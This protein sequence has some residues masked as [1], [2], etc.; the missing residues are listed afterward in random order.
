MGNRRFLGSTGRIFGVVMAVILATT[1]LAFAQASSTFNGRILDQGDAVLPGVTV[2]VTNQ[3]TGVVRTTV[4][5]EEGQYFLPGLEPG[6][7]R[8]ATELQGFQAP[9][10]ENVTLGVNTTLSIDFQM[11]VAGLN[12]A[13]TV[14]GDAPLIEVTQSKVAST[15]ETTELQNLPMI[16][17]NVSG[18]L[19]L[20]P[21]A[22][23]IAPTHRTKGNVGSV[24]FGGSAGTNM[25]PSVDGADNRDNQFGGPLVTFS[26]EALEQFQLATSQFNAADG[27][28]GGAA[29]AMITKSGT[30]VFHGSAFGFGRTDK[31]AAKDFFTKEA[32]RD[33]IPYSRAQYG[34]SLGGPILR[35]RAFFFG[36]VERIQENIETPVP[37]N[38]FDLKQL[39]VDA[40]QRG[41][42][43][44]GF[45]NPN[46]PTSVPQPARLLLT[47]AKVNMQLNN[48]HS[49]MVRYAGQD[50]FKGAATFVPENDNREPEDTKM[51]IWS[52]VG[53][54][55]WVI[56]N[57]TL[58][59]LLVQG[60]SIKRLSDTISVFTDRYFMRNYPNEPR[61]PLQLN[62]P[63]VD[64]GAGGQAGSITDTQ[65]YQV[66]DE[67]SLQS[68]SHAVKFGVNYNFLNDIGLLNGNDLYGTLS[69]F[70][71]PDV[72]LTN[73]NGRYPQGFQT[74]G[75]VESWSQANP[76][77]ADSLLDAHQFATWIQDDWRVKPQLTLNLGVRYDLDLN[78]YNQSLNENN[79]TRLVLDAVG[80]PYARRPKTPLNSVSPR[81]GV[82]Y[83]LSGDGRRVL[84]G[85]GGVYF[86][87]F[88]INGGNVSDIFSQNKR[89]LNVLSE[90]TNSTYG[91]GQLAAF[92]FGVDPVPP[93]PPPADD[94]QV[95]ARGQW[96]DPEI[97]NPYNYQAHVG[98][99][100]QLDNETSLSVDFTHVEGRNEF[101]T[102]N[103]NPR[104]NGRRVLANEFQS[105]FGVANR[106]E[107]VRI[108]ASINKSRYDALTFKVER[109]LPRATLQAHYT[110]AGAYAY[111]GSIAARG[112]A[113]LPVIADQP[114][115]EGEW[116]PTGTDERH[117]LVA[118]GVF[119]VGYGIQLSPI[120][121]AAS[122]R[123][124]NLL[125]GRDV[126]GDGTN[127]DRYID[128]ATG[129]MVAV[130]SAR[131][132]N[133]FVFDLRTTKFFDLG[134][135][136]RRIG[137]FVEVFNLFNTV[138]FG[139][140]Y[141]GNGRS[142]TFQQPNGFVPGIGYPRQAQLGL[143]F[144]F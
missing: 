80:N 116:G 125:A 96:L 3:N 83:D 39:M 70:D 111:G 93:S 134:A 53:Q 77:L 28:T 1:G 69:F 79:A 102:L 10:R 37:T 65:L 141:N 9:V 64:F 68:G 59:Q 71:D 60:N 54:H 110:L 127:I 58:N 41:L 121:Q 20:L 31:L 87:Q 26:T 89:P 27:R 90:L 78:F 40:Q 2:T 94:I 105:V 62:F 103:I 32:S 55:N 14:S 19:A 124:Y 97:G 5:N 33:K 36:A 99:A 13:I 88:N 63:S 130:N 47:T 142:S 35:N 25:V 49:V 106:L 144:L 101:R 30:N 98:Y 8:L 57:S 7:Y 46:N 108:L 11:S 16:A 140:A 118:M 44:M 133:T 100:H 12:E 136:E 56:G 122:A 51:D 73:R 82:A 50:D 66:K 123:P 107:E 126:N 129:Q 42:V 112:A 17:R 143:R 91:V 15:I 81:F 24:S 45:V 128:P 84:R 21:G 104:V 61:A 131:G 29:L 135:P 34:G 38:L 114:F 139:N 95:G 132:D 74:P 4:S 120:F 52:L 6:V 86:D 109:R 18:M 75:I 22:V 117:R 48:Q 115:A 113:P 138:N 43:P 23:Q 67:V 119:E 76:N 85:G 92:R 137:V 72:I